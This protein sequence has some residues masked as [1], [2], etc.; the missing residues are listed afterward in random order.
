MNL[1]KNT[2]SYHSDILKHIPFV[3][4]IK[5]KQKCLLLPH[6]Y[7]GKKNVSM[8][9]LEKLSELQDLAGKLEKT[10]FVELRLEIKFNNILKY[11]ID[12]FNK[13]EKMSSSYDPPDDILYAETDFK[14][15]L[16]IYF[17][18]NS[19]RK[20]DGICNLKSKKIEVRELPNKDD[21]NFLILHELIHYYECI[22]NK[23]LIYK[24]YLLLMLWEDLRRKL[25][26]KR[27]NH[28][29]QKDQHILKVEHSPFFLLYS[30][31]L[32]LKLKRPLGSVFGYRRTELF[33]N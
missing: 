10:Y 16:V 11:R 30:L 8:Q 4:N 13:K 3:V 25:G 26:E 20:Y 28:Y 9:W 21:I 18:T 2:K 19:V 14:D 27:L 29:L 1:K 22:Y 15:W 17:P 33:N 23:H 6:S 7:A 24:E 12:S 5:G 32:D 31:Y